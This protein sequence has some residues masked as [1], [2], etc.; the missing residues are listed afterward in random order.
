MRS[1]SG[2]FD[3]PST[4]KMKVLPI[5]SVM[6]ASA[7]PAMLPIVAQ[8]PLL[9]PFG[10]ILYVAWRLIRADMWPVWIT[11]PLGFWDDLFSG[12]PFGSAMLLWTIVALA[13]EVADSRLLWRDWWIDWLMGA[14][15]IAFVIWGGLM[16]IGLTGARG[17]VDIIVP[18]LAWSIFTFPLVTRLVATLD[19]WRLAR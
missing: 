7:L 11:L 5:A 14:A 6:F 8:F 4:L 2:S 9:P 18:Q 13:F 17:A 12:Q 1:T 19:R 10:I 16:I 15:A 3:P